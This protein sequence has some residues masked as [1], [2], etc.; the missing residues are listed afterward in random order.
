MGLA[1]PGVRR[2]EC[3]DQSPAHPRL[4]HPRLE[5]VFEPNALREPC[6]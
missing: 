5:H 1:D 4:A 6:P 3:L 2:V